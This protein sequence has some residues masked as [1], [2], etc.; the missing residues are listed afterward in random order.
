MAIHLTPASRM[1]VLAGMLS[2]TIGGTPTPL[3]ETFTVL[4]AGQISG[5]FDT[6][7]LGINLGDKTGM[8]VTY[9]SDR[10]IAT[11]ALL[12]DA[13]LDGTVNAADLNAVA[14]N[15][16]GNEAT[17]STGDITGDGT[18]DAQDLNKLALNWQESVP[19]V[20]NVPEP[21][22]AVLLCICVI[23]GLIRLRRIGAISG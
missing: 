11:R 21:S 10:V 8:A 18:V 14:L 2:L 13:N 19:Q 16:L 1:S 3:G 6:I 17:W 12:G 22:S 9:T 15:W 20:A 4:N 7:G 5:T 23:C